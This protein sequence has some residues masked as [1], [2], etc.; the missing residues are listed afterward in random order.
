MVVS[1]DLTQT[2][3]PST[4]VGLRQG[5][6]VITVKDGPGF[7]TTR[8]LAP[9]LSENIRILQEGLSPKDLDRLTKNYGWPVGMAT[10]ADEVGT[11]ATRD[12]LLIRICDVFNICGGRD[13][14]IVL[15]QVETQM[16]S[17]AIIV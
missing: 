17:L 2:L 15:S 5:K 8:I 11:L 10:L 4:Q 3:S 1:A 9:M 6:V 12:A 7:Y 13:L 14:L 16:V